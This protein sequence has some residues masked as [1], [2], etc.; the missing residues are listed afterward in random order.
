MEKKY[1]NIII[2]IYPSLFCDAFSHYSYSI[3]SNKEATE[4]KYYLLNHT[5]KRKKQ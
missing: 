5:D 4:L 1:L 2:L 3:T